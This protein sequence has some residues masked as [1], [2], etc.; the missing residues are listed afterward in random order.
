ML[1]CAKNERTN[2]FGQGLI[3]LFKRVVL[4]VE[5]IA[6]FEHFIQILN[7][8][9]FFLSILILQSKNRFVERLDEER[10]RGSSVQFSEIYTVFLFSFVALFFE[11]SNGF[12]VFVFLFL[13][14]MFHVE[15]HFLQTKQFLAERERERERET[16]N[17]QWF[18][19]SETYLRKL[20][21]IFGDGENLLIMFVFLVQFFLQFL[22][23]ARHR[24]ELVAEIGDFQVQLVVRLVQPLDLQ[25]QLRG[26]GV[27]RVRFVVAEQ[28]FLSFFQAS[29]LL[30]EN[31]DSHPCAFHF[32]VP[33]TLFGVEIL[34]LF[35][36]GL[37]LLTATLQRLI[38]ARQLIEPIVQL[39]ELVLHVVVLLHGHDGGGLR[40][41]D[42]GGSQIEIF[43]GAHD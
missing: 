34:V 5:V 27:V 22:T 36:D 1:A 35:V 3:L 11:Q 40:R 29:I 31:Q 4:I 19:S 37:E 14:L 13:Q 18:V 39:V 2:L 26:I 41:G 42:R 9:E 38:L 7:V 8:I 10:E 30:F 24:L 20:L 23:F 17:Q 32:L 12:L 15:F 16:A 43:D 28:F 6:L 25:F 21:L 33:L